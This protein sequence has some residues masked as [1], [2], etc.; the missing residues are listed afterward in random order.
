MSISRVSPTIAKLLPVLVPLVAETPGSDPLLV[1]VKGD[2]ALLEELRQDS[3]TPLIYMQLLSHGRQ[4]RV[5][6]AFLAA[7]Q[8]DYYCSIQIGA[9]REPDALQLF[10]A[11]NAAGVEFILL[12]GADLG[13]RVYKDPALRPMCDLDILVNQPQ[14]PQAQQV[15]GRL[16]YRLCPAS[17]D[18]RPG[19]RELF[20]YELVFAPSL[21]GSLPIDLHWE[22]RAVADFYRLPYADLRR[23]AISM[24]CQGVPVLLLSPEHLLIHLC[25]HMYADLHC[26]HL[27]YYNNRQVVDLALV[28][29]RVPVHWP[30]LLKDAD[31]FQCQAPLL[32]VLSDL[33]K[34]FPGA[35]DS[36]VLSTLACHR[37]KLAERLLLTQRLGYVTHY[38]AAFHHDP[39]QHWLRYVAAKL[40]PDRKYLTQTLGNG[41]RTA[42]LKQFLGNLRRGP[43]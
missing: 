15:L 41:S 18:P 31:R 4:G 8:H 24:D 3:L 22:I 30:T 27:S 37:P 17:V 5:E 16:G 10:Q 26:N 29:A 7:L 39:W 25:L 38:L 23:R 2:P 28:L 19:F 32:L 20:F 14:L 36:S 11:L 43:K 13:L 9:R 33:S 1:M 12:K 34:F 35:I 40:W 6:K 42:Y 21:A